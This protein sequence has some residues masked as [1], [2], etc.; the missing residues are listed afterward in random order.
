MRE[1]AAMRSRVSSERTRFHEYYKGRI[2]DADLNAIWACAENVIMRGPL[3]TGDPQGTGLVLGYVQSGKTT[4]MI[5]LTAAARDNDY[6]IVIA[7]LGMTNILLDQNAGRMSTALGFGVRDDYAWVVEANPK[8]KSAQQRIGDWLERD[9]TILIPILKH[10]GRIDALS[11][12]LSELDLA[13]TP[14]LIIDDEADQASLNVGR[15]DSPSKTYAAIS[16]LRA[17]VPLNLYVQFTATPYAPLLL[18]PDDH[19]QPDF[20]EFL[21]PGQGYTGGRE[22]FVESAKRVIRD[23]PALEEQ[24]P[25]KLPLLLPSS[26]MSA[27]GAFYAGTTL[28]LYTQAASPPISM[29][30]HSTQRNDVQERYHFLLKRQIEEWRSCVENGADY[31]LLPSV[32]RD[33]YER[34]IAL[35]HMRIPDADFIQGFTYALLETTPWLVN[36]TSDLKKVDWKVA[37]IHILIGGNKLDRG[38]TVEGLTVTYMN[39][40]PSTQVDTIEQRARAFGY[41]S[42]LLDYCQFFA[43][44]RTVRI[45]TDIVY[46]EMDLRSE[47]YDHIRSGNSIAS[48]AREIGLLIPPG[49]KVT[50][51]SVARAVIRQAAGWASARSPLLDA[52]S[53]AANHDLISQLG[54]YDAPLE[55]YGRLAFKTIWL[56]PGEIAERLLD[57]WRINEFNPGW[58][59]SDVTSLVRRYPHQD[60]PVP[61]MLME[62]HGKARDRDWNEQIGFINLFQGPDTTDPDSPEWYPGDRYVMGLREHRDQLVLQ[63]HRVK[64]HGH[65]NEVLTLAAHLGDRLLVHAQHEERGAPID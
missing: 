14:A 32:V 12:V 30:I 25:K 57:P 45:L 5:A 50:R 9:R 29:L 17:A 11:E 22:F 27:L 20:I 28:L 40:P 49:M 33:E 63:V 65:S 60:K 7:L 64:P 15:S 39:R 42:D 24:R 36:S 4:A 6:R 10:A 47:L 55:D 51:D 59:H 2:T 35:G 21:E 43:T 38:F 41:R 16:R 34:L 19:L 13:A 8:G 56:T 26:L 23:V 48:W 37:P 58:R 18:H 44:K 46:T 1:T 53:R 54:L 3:A 61:I 31:S 52:A 62:N